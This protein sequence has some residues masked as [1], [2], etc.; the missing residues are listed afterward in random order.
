MATV[1]K[2]KADIERMAEKL[3]KAQAREALKANRDKAKQ[4]SAKRRA[5]NKA[6][7]DMGGLAVKAG[8][9]DI[10]KGV[11]LGGFLAMA[12]A[13]EADPEKA[14]SWKAAGDK[15]LAGKP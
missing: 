15:A 4:A 6:K 13:I 8:L 5:D 11:L 2:I 10:D 1:D 3:A 14:K 7:Y 12:K 9:R